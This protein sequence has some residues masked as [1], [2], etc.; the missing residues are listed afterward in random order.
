M[1][2]ADRCARDECNH[3]RRVHAPVDGRC[4]VTGCECS[5]FTDDVTPAVTRGRRVVIDL[6][7][8]Y[9]ADVRIYPWVVDVTGD[10]DGA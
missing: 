3:A 8:G 5:A 6:P 1:T 4:R 2:M 10:D 7:D 9:A